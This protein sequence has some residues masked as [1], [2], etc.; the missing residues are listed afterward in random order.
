VDNAT[1]PAY[2]IYIDSNDASN[3]K[4]LVVDGNY[5][6][7]YQGI[8]ANSIA[9][10]CNGDRPISPQYKSGI[11][12]FRNEIK[13]LDPEH[14][15]Q[16]GIFL[17]QVKNFDVSNNIIYENASYS[18]GILM[19]APEKFKM[20]DKIVVANDI[21]CT[22]GDTQHE[23]LNNTC[24]NISLIYPGGKT[25][26]FHTNYGYS[27]GVIFQ[28]AQSVEYDYGYLKIGNTYLWHDFTNNV[29][30]GKSNTAPSSEIDG[31]PI[32]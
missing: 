21:Y 16:Y 7:A 2:G 23:I 26:P 1:L 31:T 12:I 4:Q 17:G 9:I 13:S 15:F 32:V 11:S 20:K 22:I 25:S 3:I 19:Y 14:R 24:D 5:I 8:A 18:E 27:S 10:N 6:V 29:L 30:R 28:I